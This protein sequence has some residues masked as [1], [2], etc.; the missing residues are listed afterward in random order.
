M[1]P[2]EPLALNLVR[3]ALKRNRNLRILL[4]GVISTVCLTVLLLTQ[5][6]HHPIFG[7]PN[8]LLAAGGIWCAGLTVLEILR[9]D[10]T[11]DDVFKL[12][13]LHPESIVWVYYYKVET[14]PYGIRISHMST[15]YLCTTDN[16]KNDL[17]TSEKQSIHIMNALRPLLPHASFGYSQQKEQLFLANPDLLKH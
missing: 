17:R 2:H 6:N 12:L 11:K 3:K 1:T 9:Y 15:L 16:I 14:M 5:N 7:F 10:V 13:Q 8:L 4:T